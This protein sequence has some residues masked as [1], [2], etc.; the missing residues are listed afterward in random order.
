MAG[1]RSK[2]QSI[3]KM[4]DESIMDTLT[5]IKDSMTTMN[6]SLTCLTE[7]V[8]RIKLEVDCIKDLKES[9]GF[10]QARLDDTNTDLKTL[11]KDQSVISL[12]QNNILKQ[13]NTSKLENQALNEKL[14][15]LDIYIRRENLKF[16]GISEDKKESVQEC[17][18]KVKAMFVDD[19]EIT[20]GAQIEFQRCHRLGVKKN[21]PRDVI[22]RFLR[23]SDREKVWAQRFKLNGKNLVIKEDFPPE[24]EQ[25]RSRLY[26]ICKAARANN[27]KASLVANYLLIDGRK[28]TMESLHLLPNYLQ[29]KNLAKK[30]DDTTVLFYGKD[31]PFSNFYKCRFIVDG[32][33]YSSVEQFYQYQRSDK[34]GDAMT[35]ASIMDTEDPIEQRRLGR[36]TRI[37][38]EIW[39][40][41]LAKSLMETA[42]MAKFEQNQDLKDDL[43]AT[44]SKLLAEC[45]K[46]DK[47]W[48]TGVGLYD[49]KVFEKNEWKG[50]NVLGCLLVRVIENLK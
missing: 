36:R 30:E 29:P 18:K 6:S 38:E 3:S 41:T 46:Y 33:Q 43:L 44:G 20:D 12:K 25:A 42:L 15:R 23:F 37:D 7:E 32:Q 9:L 1:T 47:L 49:T 48:G 31:C 4:T 17:W 45:N 5:S 19:L 34:L 24:V 2:K 22:V 26:P 10:T 50:E 35:A 40:V 14:L 27:V 11:Q 21:G 39:N 8:S 13:L 16:Q 28:Y